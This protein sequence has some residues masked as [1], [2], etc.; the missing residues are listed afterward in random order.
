MANRVSF[1]RH[2]DP[3]IFKAYLKQRGYSIRQLEMYCDTTERTIRRCLKQ[4]SVTLTIA[5]DLCQF[6][7]C[8][9]DDIFGPD[10]SKEW[11]EAMVFILKK[12]R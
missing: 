11:R 4:E 2:V 6:F 12:V 9:F 3:D 7:G 8:D 1:K 10:D 5:L